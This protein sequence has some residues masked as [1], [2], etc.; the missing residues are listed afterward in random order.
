MDN[1]FSD[2]PKKTIFACD[3][4][5]QKNPLQN[6]FGEA[7]FNALTPCVLLSL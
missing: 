5:D 3:E 6:T 4:F 1:L 7:V 2:S